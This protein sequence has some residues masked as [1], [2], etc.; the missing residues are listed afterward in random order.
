MKLSKLFGSAIAVVATIAITHYVAHAQTGNSGGN[1]GGTGGG[2]HG[3]GSG[4]G[5][6]SA[7]YGATSFTGD[8]DANPY[9]SATPT[10]HDITAGVAPPPEGT[11]KHGKHKGA[12]KASPSPSP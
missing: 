5:F 6:N 12:E 10:P 9:A 4:P 3:E 1:S 2:Q 11:P 7:G 8:P